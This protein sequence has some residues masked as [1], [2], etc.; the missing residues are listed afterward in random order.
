[1]RNRLQH[2]ADRLGI[3]RRAIRRHPFE[4]HLAGRQG[5]L[6]TPQKCGAIVMGGIVIEP[7]IQ[8]AFGLSIVYRGEPTVRALIEFIDRHVA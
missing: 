5:A 3:E 6:Q 7:F 4:L 1:M 8:D 2:L